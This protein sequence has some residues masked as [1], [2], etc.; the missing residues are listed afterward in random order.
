MD[1]FLARFNTLLGPT[2]LVCLLVVPIAFASGARSSGDDQATTSASVRVT[3]KKLK[4]QMSALNKKVRAQQK[5]LAKLE[6]CA[7]GQQNASLTCTP[8]GPAGGELTGSYPNPTIADEVGFTRLLIDG[9]CPGGHSGTCPGQWDST[10]MTLTR[11]DGF[12]T[13]TTYTGRFSGGSAYFSG[14]NGDYVVLSGAGFLDIKESSFG[15]NPGANTVRIY[16]RDFGG[17]TQLVVR[18]SDGEIDV[19]AQDD[20]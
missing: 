11:K 13:E 12:P 1:R 5:Q 3:I 9:P 15:G 10:D 6:G 2:A 8:S 16:P 17:T 14:S 4:K 7:A 20:P 18:Y 19:L